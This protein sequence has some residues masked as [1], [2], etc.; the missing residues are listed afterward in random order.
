MGPNHKYRDKGGN[1][2]NYDIPN[3]KP[4]EIGPRNQLYGYIRFRLNPYRL[5]NAKK[6][7]LQTAHTEKIISQTD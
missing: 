4:C 7:N 6:M 2:D 1:Q 3:A 5:I